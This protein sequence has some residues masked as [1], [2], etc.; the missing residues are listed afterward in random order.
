M[1]LFLLGYFEIE[2]KCWK[3]KII[4]LTRKP[5]FLCTIQWFVLKD[6]REQWMNHTKETT[7]PP[8]KTHGQSK[9]TEKK[10]YYQTNSFS[11]DE[12][13][14]KSDMETNLNKNKIIDL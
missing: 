12:W 1:N 9:F 3:T 11:D 6:S 14:Y 2:I 10:I 7:L 13:R 8:K 5:F 4:Q